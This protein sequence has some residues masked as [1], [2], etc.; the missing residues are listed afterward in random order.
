MN[1]N[2]VI[3]PGTKRFYALILL[4]ITG[5]QSYA[6]TD[7]GGKLT[8][9]HYPGF[10]YTY[11]NG[12]SSRLSLQDIATFE[13]SDHV[14]LSA[15]WRFH[16]NQHI[17][18]GSVNF[19]V[20]EWKTGLNWL[21]FG[22]ELAHLEYSDYQI[23]ENQ[24]ILISYLKPWKRMYFGLGVAYKA[25]NLL[26]GTTHSLLDWNNEANEFYPV[27][28]FR[29]DVLLRDK[30]KLKFK[31]GTYEFMRLQTKDHIFLKLEQEYV[32]LPNLRL[33]LD[34]STAVKGV[35]GMSLT[36]NELH[37]LT[38]VAFYY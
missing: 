24:A 20:E 37:I 16:L 9:I 28:L 11:E 26:Q 17:G 15:A 10:Y 23:G 19:A 33:H 34:V 38:G 3:M 7:E 13:L 35:S 32:I 27:F 4:L 6:Q 12:V 8:F 5:L 22:G 29:Y 2:Q 25:P 1:C 14:F 30:W 36:V 18:M 31:L 21:S